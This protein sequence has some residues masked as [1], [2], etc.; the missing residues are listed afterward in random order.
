MW[1][2]ASKESSANVFLGASGLGSLFKA[3]FSA[4]KIFDHF[5]SCYLEC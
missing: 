3:A 2:S 5:T 1:L 4:K